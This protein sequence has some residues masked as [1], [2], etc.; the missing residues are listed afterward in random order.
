[1]VIGKTGNVNVTSHSSVIGFL[2]YPNLT[3]HI[4]ELTNTASYRVN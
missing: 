1:M 3:Q 2:E 4:F